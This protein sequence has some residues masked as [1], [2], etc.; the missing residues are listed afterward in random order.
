MNV[1]SMYQMLNKD[2][3]FGLTKHTC[4]LS[5]SQRTSNWPKVQD[6]LISWRTSIL[7]PADTWSSE[8]PQGATG[9]GWQEPPGVPLGGLEG[10]FPKPYLAHGSEGRVAGS[11]EILN[12]QLDAAR[13]DTA[14][15]THHCGH[16]FKRLTFSITNTAP[17]KSFRDLSQG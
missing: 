6:K 3:S 17:A 4:S 15:Q 16:D 1:F 10:H 5:H 2:I 12:Q 7:L 9:K 13:D 11:I 14:S 8:E